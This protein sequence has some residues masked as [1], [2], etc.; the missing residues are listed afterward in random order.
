MFCLKKSLASLLL[1]VAVVQ[2]AKPAAPQN[3]T[4][5]IDASE[6][7]SEMSPAERNELLQRDAKELGLLIKNLP[8]HN[9]AFSAK[10]KEVL[11]ATAVGGG[12]S[13]AAQALQCWLLDG[14]ILRL[15]VA[16]PEVVGLCRFLAVISA[17]LSAGMLELANQG[18]ARP[19]LSRQEMLSLIAAAT[20]TKEAFCAAGYDMIAFDGIKNDCRNMSEEIFGLHMGSTLLGVALVIWASWLIDKK[21]WKLNELIGGADEDSRVAISHLYWEYVKAVQNGLLPHPFSHLP[22]KSSS[23]TA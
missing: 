5:L 12:I 18:D 19:S 8:K 10:L 4:A 22:K 7:M 20:V 15:R 3:L 21:K 6:R 13:L 11:L 2:V 17:A 9:K 1:L 16:P 14:K 23:A